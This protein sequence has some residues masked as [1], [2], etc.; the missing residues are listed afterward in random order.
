[1][2]FSDIFIRRPVLSTVV[3]LMIILLGAQ[4]LVNLSV[5]QYP[6]VEETVITIKTAYAGA[7]ADL[8]QGFISAPIAKAVTTTENI[9]YV[10]SSSAPSS[11][12]VTVQMK[13]GANPD[14]AL[15]EVISKVNQVRGDLPEEADDPVITRHRSGLRDDVSGRAKPEYDQRADHRVSGTRYPAAHVDDSRCRRRADFGWPG[16]LHARVDR[17]DQAGCAQDDCIGS[18][19]GDQ[20]V[21]L[22]VCAGQGGESLQ[23]FADYVEDDVADA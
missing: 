2:N 14:A 21:E 8:M 20:P 1:M 7:S 15:T 23:G 11:S 10:T 9:D 6:K 3:A 13:L 12:T 4:G 19:D 16:L 18:L 5:R 17:S 22:P